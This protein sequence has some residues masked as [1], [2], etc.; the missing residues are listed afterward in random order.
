MVS[1]LFSNA[2]FW[3][4]RPSIVVNRDQQRPKLEAEIRYEQEQESI[5]KIEKNLMN[6]QIEQKK[7]QMEA[8]KIPDT[9]RTIVQRNRKQ[10]LE[11]EIQVLNRNISL[12]KK[13]LREK[14]VL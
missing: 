6:L 7:L 14:D 4:R 3:L 8:D 11:R 10:D 2:D 1:T 13:K 5:K 12:L 9:S